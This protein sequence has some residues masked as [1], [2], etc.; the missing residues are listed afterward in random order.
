MFGELDYLRSAIFMHFR[1]SFTFFYGNFSYINGV[2]ARY[3]GDEKLP[4]LAE[5]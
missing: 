3:F 2:S 4:C 1:Q 5:L